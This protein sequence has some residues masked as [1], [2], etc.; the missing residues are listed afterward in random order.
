MTERPFATNPFQVGGPLVAGEVRRLEELRRIQVSESST[1]QDGLLNMM[2]KVIE[3]TDLLSKSAVAGD[4]T[5]AE[6]CEHLYGEINRDEQVLTKN[7]VSAGIGV[8]AMKG[9]VRF[10][11]RLKRIGDLLDVISRCCR[12]RSDGA[13]PLTDK[14]KLELDQIF[15]ILLGM[16]GYLRDGFV[17][18]RHALLTDIAKRGKTLSEILEYFRSEHWERVEAG[19]CA[20]EASS[21]YREILD[22]IKWTNEYLEKMSQD[23]LRL[24]EESPGGS[25][26]E[27]PRE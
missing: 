6:R 15:N 8:H 21:M 7:L 18:P 20:P 4:R 3:M 11:Y 27:A 17:S 9:V 12:Y 23:L 26:G 25:L 22:S 2:D 14:A 10:P 1:L 5:G 19:K 13:I 24:G 16:M